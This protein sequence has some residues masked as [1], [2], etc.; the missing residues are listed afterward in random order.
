MKADV[1]GETEDSITKDAVQN[2]AAKY[3]PASIAAIRFAD[4]IDPSWCEILLN[5]PVIA[6]HLRAA[7]GSTAQPHLYLKDICGTQFP[8]PPPSEIFEILRRV[9]DALAAADD[10][11]KEL[12]D[13]AADAARLK[14]SILK[15]AFEGRLVPQD[16]ND[17]PAS[18]LLARFGA[19][20]SYAGE[21]RRGRS[22]KRAIDLA[23]P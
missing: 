23:S 3:V 12:D 22:R 2:S 17:E 8:L 4:C 6:A 7:S 19:A 16:P 11:E 13:E 18:A 15:A 5:S 21:K 1:V 14:H 9:T 20:N 10:A